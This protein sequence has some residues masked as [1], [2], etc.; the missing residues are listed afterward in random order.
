MAR[1]S[2][3]ALLSNARRALCNMRARVSNECGD[4]LVEALAALLI[5]ALGAALL[6]TMVMVSSNVVGQTRTV[7]QAD[8]NAESQIYDITKTNASNVAM[9]IS[10]G[11]VSQPVAVTVYTS[12]DGTFVRYVGGG[13]RGA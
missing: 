5:A 8:F 4:T 11:G 10:A 1:Q 12:E 7:Q 6:A 2:N 13:K 3:F 9:T